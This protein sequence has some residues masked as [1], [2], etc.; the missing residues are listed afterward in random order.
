MFPWWADGRLRFYLRFDLSGLP[1]DSAVISATLRLNQAGGADYYLA[2]STARRPG[3]Q[4]ANG[5][6]LDLNVTD[7][8][9]HLTARNLAP[10]IFAGF[11]GQ[12][13]AFGDAT[14]TVNIPS[15]LPKQNDLA[16]FVA[17]VIVQ[18]GQVI[19]VT[20]SHW[21]TLS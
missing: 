13:D 3:L 1:A 21:F 5:E 2:A 19:Q 17:G 8:L 18:K 12:L 6:W 14:A 16:I 9:F 7:P 15:G 4:F 20:N 10:A 11:Q